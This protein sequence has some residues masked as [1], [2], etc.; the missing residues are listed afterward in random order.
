MMRMEYGMRSMMR[1]LRVLITVV[2]KH[3]SD[4]IDC[5]TRTDLRMHLDHG[6]YYQML[7]RSYEKIKKTLHWNATFSDFFIRVFK[8]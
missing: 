2:L 3:L 1:V 6:S 4:C 5:P 8:Y 7:N